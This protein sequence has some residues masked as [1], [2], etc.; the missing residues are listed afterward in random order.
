MFKE[1]MTVRERLRV[2]FTEVL[3]DF[4]VEEYFK[5]G[6]IVDDLADVA[7]EAFQAE[8]R[9]TE[10]SKKNERFRITKRRTS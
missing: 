2:A 4:G 6:S 5:T 9:K 3:D 7:L 10:R 1:D 8:L